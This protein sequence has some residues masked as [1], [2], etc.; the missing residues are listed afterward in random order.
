M[1]SKSLNCIR[2]CHLLRGFLYQ[3]EG[4]H[5]NSSPLKSGDSVRTLNLWPCHL[6]DDEILVAGPDHI[7]IM[8][9]LLHVARYPGVG[10]LKITLL[11]LKIAS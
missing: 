3:G 9:G 2:S 1:S 8:G 7:W 6:E 4:L 5:V 10:A 11:K